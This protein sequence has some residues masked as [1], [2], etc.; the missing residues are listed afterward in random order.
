MLCFL[1]EGRYYFVSTGRR[2]RQLVSVIN[3]T[4]TH[5]SLI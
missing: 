2:R 1:V 3:R 4:C 5:V